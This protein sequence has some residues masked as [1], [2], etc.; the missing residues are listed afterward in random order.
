MVEPAWAT[1]APDNDLWDEPKEKTQMDETI[2]AM[3]LAV[4]LQAI[5]SPIKRTALRN[6]LLKVFRTIKAAYPGDPDFQ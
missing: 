2:I 5:K 6:A 3:A 1:V 4:V